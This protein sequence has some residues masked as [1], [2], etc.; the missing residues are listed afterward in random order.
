MIFEIAGFVISILVLS[1]LSS[2]LV[3]TLIDIAKYLHWREFIVGF[4]IMAF[5]TSLPNLFIDVNAALHGFPQLSF[6]DIVGGNIVDLTLVMALAV[7]FSRTGISTKS[8]MVQKSALFTAIIAVLPLVLIFDGGLNRTD[9]VILLLAFFVYAF[10]IFSKEDNFQKVYQGR[11]TDKKNMDAFWL[12]KNTGKLI[13]LLALLLA[14]SYAIINAAQFFSKTLGASLALVGV[15][16]VGL[17]N[18]FPEMYFSIV[19]ARKGIGWMILGNLMGSVIVCSTLVL[20]IVSIISP[21]V[22]DDFS[23]FIIARIFVLIAA[24]FYMSS[25]RTNKKITKKEGFVLL[26][27]YILFLMTE[28][29]FR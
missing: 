24:I 5:A 14:A 2:R 1:W 8:K 16:I 4:F 10:W 17:G 20:G 26:L 11:K 22:I 19:S 12:L 29:F 25:I 6:G 27:I 7:L 15:L 13:L 28:I 18:C 3:S 21:F 23:P 9:G